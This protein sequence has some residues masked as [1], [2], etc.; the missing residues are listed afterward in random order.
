MSLLRY[1][2]SRSGLKTSHAHRAT[3]MGMKTRRKTSRNKHSRALCCGSRR[4][5]LE[6]NAGL[7]DMRT[8]RTTTPVRDG[9]LNFSLFGFTVCL[10]RANAEAPLAWPQVFAFHVTKYDRKIAKLS[11][12]RKMIYY[13][14]MNAMDRSGVR[15]KRP[16]AHA[17]PSV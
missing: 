7:R 14:I 16:S 9:K 15:C 3:T 4:S 5:V 2:N 17:S 11:T 10:F 12:L 6:A 8:K 1:I 13:E